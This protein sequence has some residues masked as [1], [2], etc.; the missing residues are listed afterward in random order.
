MLLD[1]LNKRRGAGLTTP[2]QIRCLEK[3]GFSARRHLAI[4]GCKIYD[5]SDRRQWMAC[6]SGNNPKRI[7]TRDC[8]VNLWKIK[9][10]CWRRWNTCGPE[11]Y[12][13]W[14]AVGMGLKEAGLPLQR[15]GRLERA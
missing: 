6:S 8:V 1:R 4:F 7:Q 15:V 10:I 9:M 5:R 3:Y 13:E 2:K 14:T 11:T 12:D